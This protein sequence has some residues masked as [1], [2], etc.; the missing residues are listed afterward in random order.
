MEYYFAIPSII[1]IKVDFIPS[2]IVIVKNFCDA[3]I[4]TDAELYSCYK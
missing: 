1:L 3:S 2:V 4:E